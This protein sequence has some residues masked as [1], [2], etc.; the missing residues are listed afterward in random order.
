MSGFYTQTPTRVNQYQP[1]G[2]IAAA[3][4][5]DRDIGGNAYRGNVLYIGY[6][7][8]NVYFDAV[9]LALDVPLPDGTPLS[10]GLDQN[11]PNP[12]NPSTTIVYSIPV[13]GNVRLT[14]F[15]LLGR[16]VQVLVNDHKDA[17][18][19]SHT[20]DASSLASGMYVYRLQAG[21]HMQARKLLL[22]R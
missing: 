9:D 8:A 19:Y 7:P 1:S 17:G 6:G 14:V 18:K 11:Y 10:F 5:A 15:D 2:V 21:D 22:L 13:T 3:V 16:E 12:F 20:F 4:G